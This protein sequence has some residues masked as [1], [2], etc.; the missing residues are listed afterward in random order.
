[1]MPFRLVESI[2]DETFG[3]GFYVHRERGAQIPNG[4]VSRWPIKESGV[5]EDSECPNR[6]LVWARID[7][8]GAVDLWAVSVHFLTRDAATRDREG[9]ELA[10]RLREHVPPA[11]YLVVGGDLNTKSADEPVL[12]TLGELVST[13]RLPAD[14]R[15]RTG[16]NAS[17]RRPYDWV[18]PDA[19]LEAFHVP[20]EIGGQRYP[21][22]L[23][24]DSRVFGA[25]KAVAPARKSDS[26]ADQM[27]HMA[28]VK[29]FLIPSS[30]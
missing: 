7:V 22:G 21:E 3:V 11:D 24:F 14:A 15:G 6:E 16:T 5:W 26:A 27:Q 20:V 4:V 2:V 13:R 1:M 19:D 28:V 9:R 8:P 30:E 29:D 23:V 25:L 12:R 18:L 10:A 17:R